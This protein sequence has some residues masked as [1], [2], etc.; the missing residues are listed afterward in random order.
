MRLLFIRHGDPDYVH[1]CLTETGKREAAL[2][3]EYIENL[4]PGELY[5]SPLGRAQETASYSLAKLGR[6]A[7]MF[8]WLEE[9]PGRV[10]PNL[11]EEIQKAYHIEWIEEEG[12]YKPRILWDMLPSYWGAHPELFH[13]EDWKTSEIVRCSDMLPLYDRAVSGLDSLLAEHG[14]VRDGRIYRAECPNEKTLTFFCHFGITCVLL[15]HLWNCSP[16]LLLQNT[17]TAPTSVTETVTEE[18]QRGIAAFR[19]LR[20]GDVSHLTLAGAK[21][22]FSAR[23][24]ETYD[25]KAQRHD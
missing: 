17:A 8:P 24:C 3:A 5:V 11:S 13:P 12:R 14:Y 21:P 16:F 9:F 7:V 15:S 22:S 23:F 18:R 6:E 25:N 2:L 10:D 20:M 4:N 19:M 1:D